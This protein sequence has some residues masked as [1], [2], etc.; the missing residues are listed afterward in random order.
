MKKGFWAGLL[1]LGLVLAG[2]GCGDGGGNNGDGAVFPELRSIS[3]S[4]MEVL[5]PY[6]RLLQAEVSG[7]DPRPVAWAMVNQSC[8]DRAQALEYAMATAP[9][10]PGTEP[11]VMRESDITQEYISDLASDP[12]YDTATINVAG[13]LATLQTY[14]LPDGNPVTGTPQKYYWAYHH[15]VVVNVEGTLKVLDLSAGDEPLE[16]DEW[17]HNFLDPSVECHHMNAEDF[18]DV[19]VYWNSAFSGFTPEPGTRPERLCGYTVTDMFTFRE[20]QTP[21]DLAE[22]IAFV[23]GTMQVQLGAL[24]STL[25]TEYDVTLSEDQLPLVTS[26]YEPQ[27]EEDVCDWVPELLY[28]Q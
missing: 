15:G 25:E 22:M 7:G 13:P 19:W 16:I 12:N 1:G 3:Q 28:C 11:P 4:Q 10:S 20:D 9:E 24:A 5:A 6:V 21:A 23:P 17:I 26:T 2:P 8:Q 18:L 14:V 27:T